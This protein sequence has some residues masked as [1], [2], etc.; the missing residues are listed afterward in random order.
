MLGKISA[1]QLISHI[2]NNGRSK[3][4]ME[5]SKAL[6]AEGHTSSIA[7]KSV[8]RIPQELDKRI[9]YIKMSSSCLPLIDIWRNYRQILDI[10]KKQSINIIHVHSKNL[11]WSAYFAAKKLGIPLVTT[12]HGACKGNSRLKQLYYSVIGMG[13]RVIVES[14]FTY[15]YMWKAWHIAKSKLCLIRRGID[16]D[17]F[18]PTKLNEAKSRRLR[19]RYNIPQGVPIILLPAG[20]AKWKGH[21]LV[22]DALYQLRQHSFHCLMI[23]DISTHPEF[24]KMLKKKIWEL[25]MQNKLQIFGFEP[26]TL[27]LYGLSDIVISAADEPESFRRTIIEA[28][29]MGK[30]V[31]ASDVGDIKEIIR[32]QVTGLYFKAGDLQDL[33]TNIEKAL[34]L[35]QN[36]ITD[37]NTA[38]RQSAIKTF[39][40]SEMRRKTLEVYTELVQ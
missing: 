10:A 13:D 18:D 29:A 3:E 24:V 34:E 4:V 33:V 26:D 16:C 5:I 39:S 25:K 32:H 8:A 9:E 2:S 19:E 37:L 15:R 38:A 11:A 27:N 17:Y 6:I 14:D 22:V 40:L 20:F 21:E 36:R 23:G 1:L 30:V 31:I 35:A 28:Q 12:F 7:W